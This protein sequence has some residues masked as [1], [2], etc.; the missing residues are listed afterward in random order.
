MKYVTP[1]ER[2]EGKALALLLARKD[3]Y[4]SAKAANP[5]RWSGNTRNWQ[6]A[7][8]VYLNPERPDARAAMAC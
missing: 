5:S 8:A 3:L 6:L 2:H 4:E 1:D 7:E